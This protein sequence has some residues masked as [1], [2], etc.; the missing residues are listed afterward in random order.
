MSVTHLS[1]TI[2]SVVV[3]SPLP[4]YRERCRCR[5]VGL[6]ELI[7]RASRRAGGFISPPVTGIV[8]MDYIGT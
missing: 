5:A 7:R 2:G 4:Y 8:D 1:L 6:A 3:N